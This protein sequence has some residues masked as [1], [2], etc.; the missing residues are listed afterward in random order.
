MAQRKKRP[1]DGKAGPK[2]K[3]KDDEIVVLCHP[4]GV[5]TAVPG[6]RRVNCSTCKQMVWISPATESHVQGKTHR[7]LCDECASKEA[8]D[9]EDIR[10]MP[11]A[12]GQIAE[13]LA[14]LPGTTRADI[15]KRFPLR[16]PAVRKEALEEI[17]REAA[18]RRRLK[19]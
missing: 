8:G 14:A 1:A 7:I 15:L 19:N 12:E 17:L 4:V 9:D 16:K 2:E 13:M 10:V 11:V 5:S 3:D 18:R 6:S